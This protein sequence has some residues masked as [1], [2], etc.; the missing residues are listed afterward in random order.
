MSA[1]PL[2]PPKAWLTLACFFATLSFT[3]A[4]EPPVHTWPTLTLTT[5]T[6]Y[7]DA[8]LSKIEPSAIKIIHA[9]GVARIP[10]EFLPEE[11][12]AWFP[13]DEKKAAEHRL[14]LDAEERT[15]RRLIAEEK[16]KVLDAERA[17]ARRAELGRIFDNTVAM[18]TQTVAD[19]TRPK[20]KS[21]PAAPPP[22]GTSPPPV[23][24]ETVAAAP[25]PEPIIIAPVYI[26]CPPPPAPPPETVSVGGVT[27]G[28][29]AMRGR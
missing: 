1:I 19:I 5:G 20:K 14:Q 7:H 13:Y 22:S 21:A 17:L 27:M 4:D 10:L 28:G 29:G 8:K 16:A 15:A 18:I 23:I 2:L 11:V 12:R 26:P 24:I 3:L 6:Q 9:N 25:A